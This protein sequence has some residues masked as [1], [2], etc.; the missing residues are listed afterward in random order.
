MA[1]IAKAWSAA[2]PEACREWLESL[3]MNDVTLPAAE[4]VQARASGQ[5]EST[6]NWIDRFEP[7]IRAAHLVH[8]FDAWTAAHPGAEPDT[9]AWSEQRREAWAD[10]QTLKCLGAP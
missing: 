7:G 4:W 2:D 8:A 1:G 10:L 5:L 3:P 9:S 6:V